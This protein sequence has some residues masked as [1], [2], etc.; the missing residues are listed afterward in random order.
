[1]ADRLQ[2]PD[3]SPGFVQIFLNGH[4]GLVGSPGRALPAP[5]GDCVCSRDAHVWAWNSAVKWGFSLLFPIVIAVIGMKAEH[6]YL[7]L[8]AGVAA[9]ALGTSDF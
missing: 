9:A 7:L 3:Y 4:S 8:V 2:Q 6:L 1:M 5:K